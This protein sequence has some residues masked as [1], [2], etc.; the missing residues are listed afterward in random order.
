MELA[1]TGNPHF[2][3]IIAAYGFTFLALGLVLGFSFYSYSRYK[4]QL[5]HKQA[6]KK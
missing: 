6:G 1:F 2:F 4:K 3:Y 5:S